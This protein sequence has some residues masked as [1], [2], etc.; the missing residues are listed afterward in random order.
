MS[1]TKRSVGRPK[2]TR[3][4]KLGLPVPIRF[5]PDEQKAYEDAA[6]QDGLSLS[7]WVRRVLRKVVGLG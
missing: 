4:K 5:L 6:K 1:K 2:K 3:A 7:E